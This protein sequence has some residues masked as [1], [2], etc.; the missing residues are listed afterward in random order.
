V[1]RKLESSLNDLQ[2][3]HDKLKEKLAAA[4]NKVRIRQGSRCGLLT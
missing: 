2:R 1:Q 4:A 3:Q